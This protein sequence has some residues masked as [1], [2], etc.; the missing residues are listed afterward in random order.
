MNAFLHQKRI[1]AVLI[2]VLTIGCGVLF[3][4]YGVDAAAL[5]C[6]I[7]GI[8]L[9]AIGLFYVISF[10]MAKAERL[11][12]TWGGLLVGVLCLAAGTWMAARPQSAIQ[13]M[14]Y[15]IAI[16]ILLHGLIDLQAAIQL[17]RARASYRLYALLLAVITLGLGVW[18]LL[19]PMGATKA[20]MILIGIVLIVDGI[21]DL[22][23]IIGLSRTARRLK[24]DVEMAR[25]E[26]EAVETTGTVDGKP[27]D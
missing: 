23:L 15:V 4:I 12:S 22:L 7:A 2:A 6:R 17:I 18:I 3:L 5:I 26:S 1:S 11:L 19:S 13:Y 21:T 14:Q 9:A 16:V 8:I 24:K 25:M 10:F 20:L 27:I